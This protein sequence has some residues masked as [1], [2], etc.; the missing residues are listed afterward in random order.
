[1][2][3]FLYSFFGASLGAGAE[4]AAAVSLMELT[5]FFGQLACVCLT[6]PQMKQL[7]P[8]L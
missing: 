1:M 8:F 2:K 6:S 3:F 7:P 4:A 5:G